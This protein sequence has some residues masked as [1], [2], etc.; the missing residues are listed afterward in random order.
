MACLFYSSG[1]SEISTLLW[2]HLSAEFYVSMVNIGV[3][4]PLNATKIISQR[5]MSVVFGTSTND[6]AHV[7]SQLDLY[8][9]AQAETPS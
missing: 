1:L 9:Y 3:G 4:L 7:D 8:V 2:R 6:L 5:V